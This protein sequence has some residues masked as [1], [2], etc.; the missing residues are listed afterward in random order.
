[1][2]Q[3]QANA[4]ETEATTAEDAAVTGAI[5]AMGNGA[6]AENAADSQAVARPR[7]QQHQQT[8][9]LQP[10]AGAGAPSGE[11]KAA[12]AEDTAVTEAAT[13]AEILRLRRQVQ[14][15]S[16]RAHQDRVISHDLLDAQPRLA[17]TATRQNQGSAA[18][19][20]V[21]AATA[22]DAR[23]QREMVAG[24]Q[25]KITELSA[26][27][28]Q[29]REQLTAEKAQLAAE[30]RK[31]QQLEANTEAV[32]MEFKTESATENNR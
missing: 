20:K 5:A 21:A 31:F 7:Q 30:K 19:T 10:Q 2:P 18:E 9:L 32:E 13:S 4:G 15:L 27:G 23:L 8:R 22:E 3:P 28:V 29:L 16:E 11:T 24:L 6:A 26:E 14:Q 25:L 17:A 1:M 12:A